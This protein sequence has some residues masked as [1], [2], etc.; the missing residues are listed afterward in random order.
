MRRVMYT[1]SLLLFCY[2]S[3]LPFCYSISWTIHFRVLISRP[4]AP[5]LSSFYPPFLS[6]LDEWGRSRFFIFFSGLH[7]FSFGGT[8]S[9]FV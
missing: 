6:F 4:L 3:L 8:M 1:S 5:L 9:L 2:S 7:S